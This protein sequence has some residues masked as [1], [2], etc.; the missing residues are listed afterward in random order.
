[1]GTHAKSRLD[2]L[3]STNISR[4]G[5]IKGL[6]R[7]AVGAA[8]GPLVISRAARAAAERP[9]IIVY[10]VPRATMDPQNHLNT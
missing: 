5:F 4:R 7:G 2:R 10:G 3:L 8:T 6:A 9:L 1:M